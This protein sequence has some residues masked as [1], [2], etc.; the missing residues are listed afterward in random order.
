MHS[1]D[2]DGVEACDD[3]DNCYGAHSERIR[4]ILYSSVFVGQN[5]FE[6]EGCCLLLQMQC[7]C[8]LKK[9]ALEILAAFCP[10]SCDGVI[11]LVKATR[12]GTACI[13]PQVRTKII[14]LRV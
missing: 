11:F 9:I 13:A 1:Y 5:L 10:R 14:M 3:G 2:D 8:G 7:H 4:V 6:V 12:I